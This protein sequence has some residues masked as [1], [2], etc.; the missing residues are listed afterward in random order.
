MR[1]AD[2][3][4]VFFHW[5]INSILKVATRENKCSA[6]F[7]K[8]C[9][10]ISDI[11]HISGGEGVCKRIASRGMLFCGMSNVKVFFPVII[12]EQ[13]GKASLI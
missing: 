2:E 5:L 10:N 7:R 13:S 1:V 9:I 6:I 4:I 3:N 11:G 8:F 12:P